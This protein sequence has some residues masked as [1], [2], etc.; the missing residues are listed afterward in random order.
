MKETTMNE[1]FRIN[2]SDN[3]YIKFSIAEWEGKEKADIRFFINNILGKSGFS[4]T[5][6]GMRINKELIPQMIEGLNILKEYFDN[7]GE[8]LS[9]QLPGD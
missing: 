9:D 5:K 6:K 7:N 8:K 1:L 3:V 2:I 4:A